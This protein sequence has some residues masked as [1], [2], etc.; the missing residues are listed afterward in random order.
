MNIILIDDDPE[1]LD[2]LNAAL[3]LNGFKVQVFSAPE[4]ALHGYETSH[5]DVIITD[6]HFPTMK[7][8]DVIKKIHRK[9]NKIPVIVITGD[10]SD[11]IE[12]RSRKAGAYAF[13]RKPLEIKEIIAALE[14]LAKACHNS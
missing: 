9:K 10:S 7:G 8:D 12:A 14:E 6:Y 3:R 1:C 2:S 11:D 5:T 4:Q 13:F